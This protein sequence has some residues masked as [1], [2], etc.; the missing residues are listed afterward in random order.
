MDMAGPAK[1]TDKTIGS[2]LTELSRAGPM[3]QGQG[4]LGSGWSRV[5]LSPCYSRLHLEERKMSI[6]DNNPPQ[7]SPTESGRNNS[8][9][10][11]CLGGASSMQPSC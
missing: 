9:R 2:L 5:Q 4:H 8:L 11:L 6:K 10:V 1:P 7:S 3:L